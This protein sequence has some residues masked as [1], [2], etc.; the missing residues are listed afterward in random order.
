MSGLEFHLGL[1]SREEDWSY[2]SLVHSPYLV[3]SL[4]GFSKMYSSYPLNS[5]EMNHK[6]QTNM[7]HAHH[8][9]II[10]VRYVYIAIEVLQ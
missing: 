1:F 2:N 10:R 8:T 9:R 7:G 5:M 6:F 3:Q 4:V